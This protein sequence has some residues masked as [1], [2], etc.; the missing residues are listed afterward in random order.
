V[1]LVVALA[2][3][4]ASM[5]GG[6]STATAGSVDTATIAFLPVEPTAQAIYAEGKGLFRKHGIDAKLLPLV[7]PGAT[8]AALLSGDATFA[9]ADVGALLLARSQGLPVKLVA[10]GA[11]YSSKAPTATLMSAP[12]KRYSSPRD[13]V[14]KRIGFD[15]VG[16]I[17]YVA[18]VEWLEQGGVHEADVTLVRSAFQDMIGGLSRGTFDAAVMPEPF[19]TAARRAGAKPLAPI[20]ETVCRAECL[21]TVWITRKDVDPN[22]VA[23]F[24][25]AIQEA[26]VWADRRQND[27]ASGAILARRTALQNAVIGKITRSTF[28]TRLRL[29]QVQPWIDAYARR[30]LIK[31]PFPAIDLVK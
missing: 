8:S 29:R 12:G 2:F 28:A 10:G 26:A 20:F 11:A 14:G 15:R 22:L 31:E 27:K 17:A 1:S 16:S 4:A 23:R 7:D 3:A 18:L 30:A 9:A 25:N 6:G 24:R 13:L 5:A 21:M 19:I